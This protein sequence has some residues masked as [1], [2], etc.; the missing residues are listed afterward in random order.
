MIGVADAAQSV[1]PYAITK[2]G[3]YHRALRAL[4]IEHDDSRDWRRFAAIWL[5]IVYVPILVGGLFVDRN[6]LAELLHVDIHARA[7]VVVPLFVASELLVEGRAAGVGRYLLESRLISGSELERYRAAIART[8]RLRDS[9]LGGLV[10]FG[11][12]LVTTFAG[13]RFEWVNVPAMLV[14]RFM[15]LRWV[16]RWLVWGLFLWRVSQLRLVLRATHPDRLGGLGPLLGPAYAFACVAAAGSTALVGVWADEMLYE[17]T[18]VQAYANDAIG[19]VVIAVM[20]ALVPTLVFIPNLYRTRKYGLA[21]YGAFAHRYVHAFEER[22]FGADGAEALGVPDIQSL[23]DLGGS[24]VVVTEVRVVPWGPRLVQAIVFWT[25]LPML[26][27]IAIA[28]G[29]P[30]LIQRLGKTLL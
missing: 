22:W 19:Y 7:L 14:L 2:G 17:G 23:N 3:L 27:L 11:G 8:E 13:Y 15:F 18:A 24:Y 5:A 20:F 16:W 25:V 6:W 28:I 12:A 29:I 10:L 9:Q 26:P 21:R 4:V 1:T 30:E